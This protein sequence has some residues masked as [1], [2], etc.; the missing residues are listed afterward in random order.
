MIKR[1]GQEEIV[2]FVVIVVIIAIV[3][4][5]FLGIKLRSPQ[6][7]QKDSEILYQFLE[8]ALEQT[9]DCVITTRN[10]NEKLGS[11]I[12]EC[13]SGNGLCIS[14]QTSC[15][16][17]EETFKKILENTWKV[18]NEYPYKGY[19]IRADYVLNASENSGGEEVFLINKGNCSGSYVGN[20]Y[21]LPEF[22]GNIAIKAKLCMN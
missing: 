1:K 2:G 9:T 20:S 5:I 16:A 18:G 8:S 13:H 4:V 14:G 3:F 21:W 12:R 22:P 7:V 17:S 10:K 6:P 15:G 19:E 11:L